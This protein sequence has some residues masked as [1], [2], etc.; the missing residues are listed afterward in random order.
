[1]CLD[2][3][4]MQGAEIFALTFTRQAFA[5]F[6]QHHSLSHHRQELTD[7]MLYSR[8]LPTRAWRTLA[9]TTSRHTAQR[10]AR[11]SLETPNPQH[12][13]QLFPFGTQP[14]APAGASESEVLHDLLP[15]PIEH[16]DDGFITLCPPDKIRH[17]YMKKFS[18]EWI[19]CT[20]KYDTEEF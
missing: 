20:V 18:T 10:R 3:I 16:Y 6:T 11:S 13:Y 7:T 2:E 5:H 14:F 9:C 15:I 12:L 8:A 4:R 19:F 17:L 1:M